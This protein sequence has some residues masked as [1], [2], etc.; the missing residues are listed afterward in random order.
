MITT[1][2]LLDN[3]WLAVKELKYPEKNV[4]GYVFSHEASCGGKKIAILPYR[5]NEKGECE[6]LLRKEYTP[7][8]DSEH[9]IISSITGGV[10][11]NDPIK[12]C[13]EELEEEAGYRV[14]P[15]IIE[16]LGECFGVKSADTV[17][18]LFTVDL[19]N[20]PQG[21][22][23]TTDLQEQVSHCY[24]TADLDDVKQAG[25]PLVAVLY[26]RMEVDVQH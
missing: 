21:K 26:L 22:P 23:T 10:I 13:I 8:W 17:Y 9:L 19:T 25:D 11:D 2:T 12:T 15:T 7:C 20:I 3:K 18:Y 4:P 14:P 24:W 1:K 16:P 6:I 5:Y